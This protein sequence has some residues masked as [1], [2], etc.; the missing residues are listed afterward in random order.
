MALFRALLR[1]LFLI[2]Y[3]KSHLPAN[4]VNENLPSGG[5]KWRCHEKIGQFKFFFDLVLFSLKFFVCICNELI[6]KNENL[7][8]TLKPNNFPHLFQKQLSFF[9]YNKSVVRLTGHKLIDTSWLT[10]IFT[11]LANVNVLSHVP[12]FLAQEIWSQ[13]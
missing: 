3:F 10:Q 6:L 11:K 8:L 9:C 7:W 5:V 1:K 4:V 2:A 12:V 13:I